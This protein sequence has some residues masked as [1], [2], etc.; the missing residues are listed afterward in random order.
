MK[1]SHFW[2]GLALAGALGLQP[3]A[4]MAE[5]ITGGGGCSGAIESQ[6]DGTFEG[7]S[8]ETVF[9]LTNGQ[10]WQQSSYAYT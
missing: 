6:I 2:L 4:A 3:V 8:G 10:I 7:W 1:K 9:K 5:T